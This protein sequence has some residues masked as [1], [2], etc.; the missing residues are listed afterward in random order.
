MLGSDV[1]CKLMPAACVGVLLMVHI[2]LGSW[3]SSSAAAKSDSGVSLWVLD[4]LKTTV[5]INIFN[6]KIAK[7]HNVAI[8]LGCHFFS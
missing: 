2:N 6:I 8:V 7:K 5:K 4:A 3:R 1:Q